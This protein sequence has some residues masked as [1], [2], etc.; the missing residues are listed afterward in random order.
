MFDNGAYVP[1]VA[2]TNDD[3]VNH[4]GAAPDTAE[5]SLGFRLMQ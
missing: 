1:F 5:W 2:S 3:D 4:Q